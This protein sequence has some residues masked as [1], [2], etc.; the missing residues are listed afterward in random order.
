MALQ[1]MNKNNQREVRWGVSKAAVNHVN[2]WCW[3]VV[4]LSNLG[5]YDSRF[6]YCIDYFS[7]QMLSE[8]L[9]TWPPYCIQLNRSTKLCPP[10]KPTFSFYSQTVTKTCFWR[11]LRWEICNAVTESWIIFDQSSSLILANVIR[12]SR[13]DMIFFYRLYVSVVFIKATNCSFVLSYC[14]CYTWMGLKWACQDFGK[15]RGRVS[16]IPLI[17][18][19]IKSH[20]HRK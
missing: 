1:D 14:E 11:H 15:C 9:V 20:T 16:I 12:G 5:K 4:W 17:H 6:C 13:R 3:T 18:L 19:Y 10:A 8:T 7:L 2:H